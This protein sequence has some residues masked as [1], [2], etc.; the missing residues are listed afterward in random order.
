MKGTA[1]K[2]IR[3]I[4]LALLATVTLAPQA[5]AVGY[6]GR[7]Y[8]PNLQRW[9]QR[10]PIGEQGGINLYQFVGNNPL[11]NIDPDGLYARVTVT[12]P[13]VEIEIPLTFRGKGATPENIRRFQDAIQKMWSGQFGQY[14]VTAK[15]TK[16]AKDCPRDKRNIID[17]PHKVPKVQRAFVNP[18]DISG[19][20]PAKTTDWSASHEAG[21][22]MGLPDHYNYNNFKPDPNFPNNIM[23]TY[24]GKPN[25]QDIEGIINAAGND[26][27]YGD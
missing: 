15:I 19:V 4:L 6:W 3:P 14:H 5:R 23:S 16:P 26:V 17:V 13:D 12:G 27:D 11:S 8:D 20:W 25:Q 7:M 18:D 1:V 21:H 24:G 10:D 2:T 22:L 9:I